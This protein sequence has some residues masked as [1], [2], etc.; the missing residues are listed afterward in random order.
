MGAM[1]FAWAGAIALGVSCGAARA[2]MAPCP[3][4]D[5]LPT[6]PPP[7]LFPLNVFGRP[8]VP[9]WMRQSGSERLV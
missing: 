7:Y 9:R 1:K 5:P 8:S 6:T 3:P 2:Q 4:Q